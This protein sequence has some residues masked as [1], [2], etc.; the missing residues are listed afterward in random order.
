[1]TRLLAP[2]L[3]LAMAGAA[4]GVEGVTWR[5]TTIDVAADAEVGEVSAIATFTNDSETPV[6]IGAITTR[7]GCI[8]AD[9]VGDDKRVE[10][11]ATGQL[12]ISFDPG[13]SAGTA[14]R[15]VDVELVRPEGRFTDKLDLRCAVNAPIRLG[16]RAVFWSTQDPRT[17]KSLDIEVLDASYELVTAT[18]DDARFSVRLEK[19]ST[20]GYRVVVTPPDERTAR[21]TIV[22]TSNRESGRMRTITLH[23]FLL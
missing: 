14:H 1:M 2:L 11:H 15:S 12:L 23:A 19:P 9:V 22:L 5:A 3:A 20:G 8:H 6:D 18:C 13:Y 4:P 7:C 10:P 21:A 16:S 17:E